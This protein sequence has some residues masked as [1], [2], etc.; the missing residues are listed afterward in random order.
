MQ[1]RVVGIREEQIPSMLGDEDLQ[2][3]GNYDLNYINNCP[4]RLPEK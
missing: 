1:C 2:G 3:Y 4:M